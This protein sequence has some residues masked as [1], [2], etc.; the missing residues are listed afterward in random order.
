VSTYAT[1]RREESKAETAVRKDQEVGEKEG[2]E[3]EG[4][5]AHCRGHDQQDAPQE[6]RDEE[7]AIQKEIASLAQLPTL[8]LRG[9]GG[10]TWPDKLLREA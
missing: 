4:G 6:G 9:K 7:F 8:S 2:K 1:K 10:A 5:Q 3:H